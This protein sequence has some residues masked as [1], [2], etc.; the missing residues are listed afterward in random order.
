M[1]RQ[2]NILGI[3]A[4]GSFILGMIPDVGMWFSIVG[5]I[6]TMILY[7]QVDK[8]GYGTNLFKI[9]LYQLLA[10]IAPVLVLSLLGIKFADSGNDRGIALVLVGLCLV[11]LLFL[12]WVNYLVA[13]NLSVI[14]QKSANFWFKLSGSLTKAGAYTMP[15]LVG[16]LLVM[17]AQPIFLLGC[18]VYK[19][20]DVSNNSVD[21]LIN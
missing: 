20:L 13:K 12:A 5:M 15:V 7:N 18:I 8:L 2:I 1:T 14:G 10:V 19:P 11:L 17:L 3:I 21:K 9:N 16:L 6:L 4:L